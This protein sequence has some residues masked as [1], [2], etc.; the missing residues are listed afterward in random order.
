[1]NDPMAIL[2]AD[3]REVKKLL[4][5][6]GESEEGPEREKMANEVEAA[7]TLHMKIEEEILYPAVAKY[8]GQEDEEEAQIEHGLAREGLSKMM[9]MVEMPG[10]GATAEMLLGGIEHHVKEEETELLPELK[11]A[12]PKQDWLALGDRIAQAKAD[13]GRPAAPPTRRRSQKR[14]SNS[15]RR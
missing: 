8:V 2:R 4:T 9:S 10:F 12:L 5:S 15:K 1:M 11:D 7:L 6:L 3:H 13:A 14:R